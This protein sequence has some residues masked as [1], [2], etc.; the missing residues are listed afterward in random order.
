MDSLWD[1]N[2]L[3]CEKIE[4]VVKQG[5]ISPTE[6][7]NVYKATKTLYYIQCIDA[8]LNAGEGYE[9][10][11]EGMNSSRRGRRSYD[12]YAQ[13]GGGGNSNR[14]GS[15]SRM[16]MARGGG[17]S[18]HESKQMLMQKIAEIEQQIEQME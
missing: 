18:G 16:S 13:G 11:F 6:M 7:D 8:M 5:D 12:S 10:S 9:E 1:L 15:Y 14:R 3:L 2:D 4:E 17:Y